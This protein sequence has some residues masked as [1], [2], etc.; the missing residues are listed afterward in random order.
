MRALG[1]KHPDPAQLAAA[2]K[3]AGVPAAIKHAGPGNAGYAPSKHYPINAQ[4]SLQSG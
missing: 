4:V 2:L 1:D 3:E